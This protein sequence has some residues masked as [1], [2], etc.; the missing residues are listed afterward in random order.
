MDSALANAK[1]IITN[2][3]YA[4]PNGNEYKI[5]YQRIPSEARKV[6]MY[7]MRVHTQCPLNEIVLQFQTR[8]S[9][10]V[11]SIRAIEDLLLQPNSGMKEKVRAITE[12]INNR[13]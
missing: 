11:N 13:P 10:V 4:L 6:A 3:I 8:E 12:A 2:M 9:T 1:L 7:L 5:V